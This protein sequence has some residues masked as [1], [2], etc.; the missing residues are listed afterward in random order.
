MDDSKSV[1][2]ITMDVSPGQDTFTV[3]DTIDL[4]SISVGSLNGLGYTD[5]TIN[6]GDIQLDYVT[7]YYKEQ[8]IVSEYREE[9]KIRERNPG[10]QAAW[11][12]YKILVEL[13]KNPPENLDE[14]K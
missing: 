6:T 13:A 11:E 8:E 1:Y 10:I 4:S 14:T 3:T 7:D 9:E 2:T 12:A 5:I